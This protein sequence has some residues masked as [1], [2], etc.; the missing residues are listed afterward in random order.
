MDEDRL[1][2][3]RASTFGLRWSP[4]TGPCRGRYVVAGKIFSIDF[5][6]PTCPGG[7]GSSE[8]IW[9]RHGNQ[10]RFSRIRAADSGDEIFWGHKPWLK[11]G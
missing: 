3:R 4:P 2:M 5:N 11:I 6:V 1:S 9:F 8:A 10:L 7:A